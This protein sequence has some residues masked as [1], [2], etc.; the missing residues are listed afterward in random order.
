MAKCEPWSEI[1][2]ECFNALQFVE[3][4]GWLTLDDAHDVGNTSEPTVGRGWQAGG[5]QG[6]GGHQSSQRHTSSWSPMSGHCSVIAPHLVNVTHPC[7]HLVDVPHLVNVPHL[8][9][10]TH[11]CPHLVNVT[12]LCPHLV[13]ATH[14]CMTTPWRK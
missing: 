4:I 9:C 7:P 14:P 1:Y 6:H 8:V 13:G 2:T 11:S 12:H 5:R 10:V 3:E